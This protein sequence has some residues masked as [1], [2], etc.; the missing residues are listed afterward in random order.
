MDRPACHLLGLSHLNV[1]RHTLDNDKEHRRMVSFA[2]GFSILIFSDATDVVALIAVAAIWALVV[3]LT[4]WPGL[5]ANNLHLSTIA[6]AITKSCK[7]FRD[8]GPKYG[9]DECISFYFVL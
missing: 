1:V 6:E 5:A 3:I 2:I 9:C 8:D 7:K 4:I